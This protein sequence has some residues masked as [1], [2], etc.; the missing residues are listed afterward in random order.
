MAERERDLI[1]LLLE[2][3]PDSSLHRLWIPKNNDLDR[4]LLT[5]AIQAPDP[6]VHAHRVPWQVNVNQTI[7][8]LLQ[9]DPLA[10]SFGR[11]QEPYATCVELIGSIET[12]LGQGPAFARRKHHVVGA[13]VA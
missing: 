8:A 5:I 4:P 2:D 11:D 12:R 13:V 10:S 9:V 6:L 1:H 7:A 3:L